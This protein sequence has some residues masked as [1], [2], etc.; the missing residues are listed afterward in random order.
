MLLKE[1]LFSATSAFAFIL[2]ALENFEG[3]NTICELV[4]EVGQN[5]QQE[6]R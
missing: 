4:G 5:P 3:W 6:R 1:P 2:H